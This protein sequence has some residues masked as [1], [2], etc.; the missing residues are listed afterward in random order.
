MYY[1]KP[2][3]FQVL[4]TTLMAFVGMNFAAGQTRNQFT[5]NNAQYIIDSILNRPLDAPDNQLALL[6]E[7]VLE[8]YLPPVYMDK[9]EKAL[10][11][12]GRMK[13][14]N[15]LAGIVAAA[16]RHRQQK[17]DDWGT[18]WNYYLQFSKINKNT[19]KAAPKASTQ[20][21]QPRQRTTEQKPTK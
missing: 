1:S 12:P 8:G 21:I 14:G 7:A 11:D 20:K 2:K 18:K 16:N 5:D 4:A 10:T 6:F 9:L 3:R 19:Q 13:N 15:L 17:I